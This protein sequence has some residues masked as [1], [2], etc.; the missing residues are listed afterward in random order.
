MK[1]FFGILVILLMSWNITF[2]A[3]DYSVS[4]ITLNE[5]LKTPLDSVKVVLV[6]NGVKLDSTY[7]SMTKVNGKMRAYFEF[8]K[9]TPGTY[10]CFFSHKGYEST[11]VTFQMKKGSKFLAGWTFCMVRPVIIG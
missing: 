9:M 7:S 8:H 2:A 1:R 3:I 6:K 5:I 11:E 10:Q 4:G